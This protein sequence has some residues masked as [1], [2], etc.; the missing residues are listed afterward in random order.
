MEVLTALA[1]WHKIAKDGALSKAEVGCVVGA[2]MG[3]IKKENQ[4]EFNRKLL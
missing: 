1:K 3:W 2:I 4:A